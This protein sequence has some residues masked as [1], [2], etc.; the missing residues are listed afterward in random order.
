MSRVENRDKE[1]ARMYPTPGLFKHEVLGQD[2]FGKDLK[3]GDL[4]LLPD[5]F[6]IDE[7]TF[8]VGEDEVF[9]SKS[10]IETNKKVVKE[11]A[12]LGIPTEALYTENISEEVVMWDDVYILAIYGMTPVFVPYH[13][14]NFSHVNMSDYSV[15]EKS[16]L[17]GYEGDLGTMFDNNPL[18]GEF[19]VKKI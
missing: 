6:E 8:N 16:E 4:V 2:I 15:L 13:Y 3:V 1:V 19:A 11:D 17:T 7:L 9:F 18:T 5:I 12:E 10:K 14:N